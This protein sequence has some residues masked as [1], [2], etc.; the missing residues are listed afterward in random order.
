MTTFLIERSDALMT[1]PLDVNGPFW[2]NKSQYVP[3]PIR[4]TN[5]HLWAAVKG[6]DTRA[7][8]AW[9]STA[10]GVPGSWT[11]MG[12]W[13]APTG[14]TNPDAKYCLDPVLT[15]E[16]PSATIH[17]HWKGGNHLAD[18]GYGPFWSVMH[19]RAPESDPM[20]LVR[21]PT[22]VITSA[23][24]LAFCQTYK[25]A[26]GVTAIG[27]LYLSD[28][29][30]DPWNVIVGWGG[31]RN[32]ADGRY[33]IARFRG[34]WTD[35]TLRPEGWLSPGPGF[36][37]VQGPCVSMIDG[38]YTMI[39]TEGNDTG[40]LGSLHQTTVRCA[41]DGNWAW[42]PRGTAFLRQRTDPT[43]WDSHKCYCASLLKGGPRYDTPILIE[44]S[45][46]LFYS[47][48]SASDWLRARSGCA[49]LTPTTGIES[50]TL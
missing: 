17:L 42:G 12:V 43:L 24:V 39:L 16:A 28:I 36:D 26:M 23:Q 25:A 2:E 48:V 1:L 7:I 41:A 40:L 47:A 34:D 3:K 27:D 5:G 32:Q 18:G 22:P 9:R 37:I 21:T 46:R 13:A 10:N 30:R 45:W 8:H 19:G 11:W 20:A 15:F 33:H 6:D 31:F 49:L 14:G 44:G 29:I 38:G 50:I 35:L 4:L